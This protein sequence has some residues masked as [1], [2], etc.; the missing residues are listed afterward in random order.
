MNRDP[1]KVSTSGHW[2]ECVNCGSRERNSICRSCD[3]PRDETRVDESRPVSVDA[4]KS[5]WDFIIEGLT[6]GGFTGSGSKP[7]DVAMVIGLWTFTA[8]AIALFGA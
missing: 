4:D 7:K 8:I 3:Q 2:A 1:Y 6:L 5:N